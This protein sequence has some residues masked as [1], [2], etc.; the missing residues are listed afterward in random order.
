MTTDNIAVAHAVYDAY[1]SKDRAAAERLLAADFSFTSPLD[2]GL[3]RNSYFAICWPNSADA[4]AFEIVHIAEHG[5]QVF[6]TYEGKG[7]Q[8]S[9]RNTEVL[10]VYD[11]R[12]ARIEV[13]FGWMFPTTS[14]RESIATRF[15]DWVHAQWQD[16]RRAERRP[17][18]DH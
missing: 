1:V 8:S 18:R 10:T 6:V 11:G 3:D 5:D 7:K 15:K 2:N 14:R 13:Y 17:I 4:V 9:F 12:I 16:L